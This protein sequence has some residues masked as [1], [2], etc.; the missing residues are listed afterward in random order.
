[1]YPFPWHV[2]H[3]NTVKM[4]VNVYGSCTAFEN[5]VTQL[6]Y[7]FWRQQIELLTVYRCIYIAPSIYRATKKTVCDIQWDTSVALLCIVI[8]MSHQ[9]GHVL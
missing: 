8:Q 3:Q 9:G 7:N 2:L 6:Q 4:V 5:I 1:M